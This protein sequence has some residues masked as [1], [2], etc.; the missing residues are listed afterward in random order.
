MFSVVY[1]ALGI[2]I[3]LPIIVA[4]YSFGL[5]FMLLSITPSGLGFAEPA[6]AIVLI[7]MGVGS[8]IALAGVLIFRLIT[9]WLPLP[10]GLYFLKKQVWTKP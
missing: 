6:M 8:E 2:H 9:Y 4:S 1:L 3:A 10:L 7:S 5:L